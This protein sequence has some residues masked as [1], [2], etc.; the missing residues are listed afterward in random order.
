MS[1][2][3]LTASQDQHDKTLLCKDTD[4][5]EECLTNQTSQHK[6]ICSWTVHETLCDFQLAT[7][8]FMACQCSYL[9]NCASCIWQT[10]HSS[11]QLERKWRSH[12]QHC[13]LDWLRTQFLQHN[14][15]NGQPLP[16]HHNGSVKTV[17]VSKEDPRA[18]VLICDG[19]GSHTA[20]PVLNL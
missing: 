5:E 18:L 3:S 8:P 2:R 15:G 13:P 14:N 6:S 11:V 19:H 4:K 7:S 20:L 17:S 9:N 12:Q 10:A 16:L 1:G